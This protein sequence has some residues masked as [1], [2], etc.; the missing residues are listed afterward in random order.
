M[1][2]SSPSPETVAMKKAKAEVAEARRMQAEAM[3]SA[4]RMLNKRLGLTT[5]K[6][7]KIFDVTEDKELASGNKYKKK[8]LKAHFSLFLFY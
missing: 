7:A 5:E 8:K 2:R 6:P 1:K 4:S 3:I